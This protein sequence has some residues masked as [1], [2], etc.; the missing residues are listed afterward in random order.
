MA[1]HIVPRHCMQALCPCTATSHCTPALYPVTVPTHCTQ[2][3]C[4][5][6][7]PSQCNQSLYPVTVRRRC[8]QSLYAGLYPVPVSRQHTGFRR[9]AAPVCHALP[10]PRRVSANRAATRGVRRAL[11]QLQPARRLVESRHSVSSAFFL[12]WAPRMHA[13]S[14]TRK[15]SQT[16]VSPRGAC[17]R[18]REKTRKQRKTENQRNGQTLEQSACMHG[19]LH[20]SQAQ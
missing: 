2:T 15:P 12:F 19:H 17:T 7:V 20:T 6:A 18:A 16:Y 4:T 14:H 5:G 13:L 10:S 11:L 1:S 9:C 3:R 8:I